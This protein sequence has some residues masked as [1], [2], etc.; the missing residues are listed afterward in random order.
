MH[1]DEPEAPQTRCPWRSSHRAQNQAI[2]A[3]RG[4]PRRAAHPTPP[5]GARN[6]GISWCSAWTQLGARSP[7]RNWLQIRGQDRHG[8]E[9]P[10]YDP[11]ATSHRRSTRADCCPLRVFLAI[12]SLTTRVLARRMAKRLLL[13]HG[14]LTHCRT[15]RTTGLG[16]GDQMPLQSHMIGTCHS[17]VDRLVDPVHG[18][19]VNTRRSLALPSSLAPCTSNTLPNVLPSMTHTAWVPAEGVM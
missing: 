16:W 17:M 8:A 15:L 9:G 1:P 6:P 19:C 3:V 5:P 12:H 4:G 14:L 7:R 10:R 13:W 18:V 11:I 2:A